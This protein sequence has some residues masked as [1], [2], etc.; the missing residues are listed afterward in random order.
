[1][2]KSYVASTVSRRAKYTLRISKA[3][4][5]MRYREARNMLGHLDGFLGCRFM[6]SGDLFVKFKTTHDAIAAKSRLSAWAPEE[7]HPLDTLDVTVAV[8]DLILDEEHDDRRSRKR[9]RN[10]EHSRSRSHSR[11]E[12]T[13]DRRE[14]CTV[15]VAD[16]PETVTMCD[17]DV[18]FSVFADYKETRVVSK[19]RKCFAFVDVYG[20]ACRELICDTYANGL[21]IDGRRVRVY[22]SH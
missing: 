8:H 15:F 21:E 12:P 5:D 10:R 7:S 19:D 16:I 11:S 22:K 9:N 3:P 4:S 20:E 18:I 6:P 14:V 1:M 13:D 17:L 2:M